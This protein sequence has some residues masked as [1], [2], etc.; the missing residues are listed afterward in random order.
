MVDKKDALEVVVFMLK[1]PCLD[2]GHFFVAFTKTFIHVPDPNLFRPEGILPNAGNGKA[3][4]IEI[5]G[6]IAEIQD[7]GIDVS[8]PDFCIGG[9]RIQG[10]NNKN[11]A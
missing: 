8:F 9:V 1:H 4:F 11:P 2:P 5:A 10:I 3:S 6:F 7:F